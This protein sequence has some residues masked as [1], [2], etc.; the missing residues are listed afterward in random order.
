[1]SSDQGIKPRVQ[2][3]P[4]TS[5]TLLNDRAFIQDIYPHRK[6]HVVSGYDLGPC[7][8]KWNGNYLANIGGQQIV[9]LH[10]STH[11]KMDFISKNFSYK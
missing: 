1:M 10:V 5:A 7:M 8:H 9:K 11:Q 2:Q 6:P 4:K 3:V